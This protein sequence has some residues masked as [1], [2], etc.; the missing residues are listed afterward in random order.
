MNA[1]GNMNENN[2]TFRKP[3]GVPIEDK[4]P[5]QTEISLGNDS[6]YSFINSGIFFTVGKKDVIIK[7]EARIPSTQNIKP[8]L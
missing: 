2:S 4:S 8:F 5:N 1:N 6:T 7:S 3:S